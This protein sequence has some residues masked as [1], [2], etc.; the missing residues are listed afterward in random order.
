MDLTL[1]IDVSSNKAL[2]GT[3]K[4]AEETCHPHVLSLLKVEI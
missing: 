1:K 4:R 3:I 2:A